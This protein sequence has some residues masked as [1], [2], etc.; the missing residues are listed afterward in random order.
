[1]NIVKSHDRQLFL[2]ILL[3]VN[4]QTLIGLLF[5]ENVHHWSKFKAR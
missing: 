4:N 5:S 2:V 3:T 1:M